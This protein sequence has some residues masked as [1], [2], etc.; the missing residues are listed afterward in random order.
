M[1]DTKAVKVTKAPSDGR[2]QVNFARQGGGAHGAYSTSTPLAVH[3]TFR[4]QPA[5]HSV[6]AGN[7]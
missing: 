4:M 3:D 2:K 1:P 6:M 5:E 7:H